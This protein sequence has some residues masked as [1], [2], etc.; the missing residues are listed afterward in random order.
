MPFDLKLTFTGMILYVPE[1]T[2]LQLLMPK[3][4]ETIPAPVILPEGHTGTTCHATGDCMEPHAARITFDTAYTRQGAQGPD[5]VDRK[6]TRL[7]S[8]H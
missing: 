3:T 7:N 2:Q 1:L 5:G 6:S 4:P 8:S